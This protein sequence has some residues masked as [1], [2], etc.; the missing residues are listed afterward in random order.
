MDHYCFTDIYLSINSLVPVNKN[1]KAAPRYD[2]IDAVPSGLTATSPVLPESGKH[3][4][5]DGRTERSSPSIIGRKASVED[6]DQTDEQGPFSK[7]SVK[8]KPKA[9]DGRGLR[10]S[11]RITS[12]PA[13]SKKMRN[14]R[15]IWDDELVVNEDLFGITKVDGNGNLLGGRQYR[16][17]VFTVLNRGARLYM[18]STE[19]ARCM[20][21]L[22]SYQLF[23]KH[24]EL[25]KVAT[26]YEEKSDLIDREI[27]P[28]NYKGRPIYLVTARSI[29]RE[30]GA[31]IVVGGLRVVDD[32]W[33]TRERQRGAKEGELA[34]PNNELPV[35]GQEYD[36]NRY[37][38]WI[39]ASRMYKELTEQRKKKEGAPSTIQSPLVE[40]V[41]FKGRSNSHQANYGGDT[42]EDAEED[43]VSEHS[44]VLADPSHPV[45]EVGYPSTEGHPLAGN[46][47]AALEGNNPATA[48]NTEIDGSEPFNDINQANSFDSLFKDIVQQSESRYADYGSGSGYATDGMARFNSN[49]ARLAREFE[50]AELWG[51]DFFYRK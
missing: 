12:I 11:K 39:G 44:F 18:H 9:Q 41:T 23:R 51:Y 7:N 32:F 31:R 33:E 21:Y 37:V 13:I 15:S 24:K 17:C 16:C 42:E 36:R 28:T 49:R 35:S 48:P 43:N 26:S 8:L 3:L 46:F 30:F 34:V 27:I 6:G 14:D 47:G 4:T 5:R 29:F 22:D 25:Y 1:Q 10:D 45:F 50:W 2:D 19:L 20:G 38:A 40:D